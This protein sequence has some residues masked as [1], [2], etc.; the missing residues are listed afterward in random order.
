MVAYSFKKRFAAP[1]R[2]GT[3]AQTIRAQRKR[4]AR[5][6][7]EAQL[8]T[9]MRTKHCKLIGRSIC[10][11]V[12]SVR[13][14]F[15]RAYGPMSFFIDGVLLGCDAME[16]FAQADGFGADGGIAVLDMAAFWFDAHGGAGDEIDFAGVVIR[17]QPPRPSA[18]EID[19]ILE[20]QEPVP[21]G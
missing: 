7:E 6:G 20:Q 16:A 11:S 4:H 5:P 3:K 21:C 18:D 1:I 15:H 8:Y 2:A 17:W 14:T 13:L 10:E 12:M 9:G 19:A